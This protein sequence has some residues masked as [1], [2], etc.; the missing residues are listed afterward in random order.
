MR[1]VIL[2]FFFFGLIGIPT[3]FSTIWFT[4]PVQGYFG[5]DSNAQD[6]GLSN[7]VMN[8]SFQMISKSDSGLSSSPRMC[9]RGAG[10]Y[11]FQSDSKVM[12]FWAFSNKVSYL[13]TS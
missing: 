7:C 9:T 5:E 13:C 6:G 10:M 2:F 11:E 3:N 8:L 12:R 4:I 1:G